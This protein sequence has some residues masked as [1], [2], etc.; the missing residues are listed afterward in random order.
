MG[1]IAQSLGET[2]HLSPLLRKAARLG[3]PT[4]GDLL[5]L[6]VFRGCSHYTPPDYDGSTVC[7]PGRD[8]WSN[9]ELAVALLSAA[10]VYDPHLIRCAA[11]L[12]G[13]PDIQP[14][15][16]CRLARMERCGPVVRHIA[17]AAV[18]HDQG[19]EAFWREV[20]AG[21]PPG[22]PVRPGVMPH[23]T[24]FLVQTGVSGPASPMR[25]RSIWLRPRSVTR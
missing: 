1:T 24:R 23:P 19:H 10:Q 7:E 16:L 13:S 22:R 3:L 11:Q 9:L 14:R 15:A 25:N 17:N 8:Q 2:V 4:A 20:L 12:L 5:R 6:A 21:L 18:R